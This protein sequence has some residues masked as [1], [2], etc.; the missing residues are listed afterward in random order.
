MGMTY[1]EEHENVAH[2]VDD[3]HSVGSQAQHKDGDNELEDSQDNE[4]F[5]V[6]GDVLPAGNT[7]G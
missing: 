5:R 4:A 7:V 6:V 2:E 3:S 1:C